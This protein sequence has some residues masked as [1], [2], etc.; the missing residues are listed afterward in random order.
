[1]FAAAHGQEFSNM[2]KLKNMALAN[3]PLSGKR[4]VSFDP[5]DS[6]PAKVV[7]A[8]PPVS[9]TAFNTK[10][11]RYAYALQAYTCERRPDGW[12]ICR[13]PF[14]AAGEKPAW[15]GPFA[16]IETAMIAIARRLATEAADR[17]TRSIE[18]HNI[19][20]TDAL[21][22]LKPTTGLSQTKSTSTT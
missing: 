7:R 16:T 15:S 22:G 1:M 20:P 8:K 13:T 14:T 3:A 18:A 5:T 17:H 19:E 21:Y 9:T 11:L 2:G 6:V 4:V 10:P 12:Y